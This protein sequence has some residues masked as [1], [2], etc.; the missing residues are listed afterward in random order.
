MESK[1]EHRVECFICGGFYRADNYHINLICKGCQYK[2]K[3]ELIAKFLRD[4]RWGKAFQF[5][6]PNINKMCKCPEVWDYWNWFEKKW[7][8]KLQEGE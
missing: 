3:Q 5:H 8:K 1:L 4:W 6:L 7:Q 2:E